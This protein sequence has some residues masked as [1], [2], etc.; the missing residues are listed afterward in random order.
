MESTNSYSLLCRQ[1]CCKAWQLYIPWVCR[2]VQLWNNQNTCR[3]ATR[4]R[5]KTLFLIWSWRLRILETTPPLSYN[6]GYQ[7]FVSRV[8]WDVWVSAA[9]RERREEVSGTKGTELIS[10]TAKLPP[11]GLLWVSSNFGVDSGQ[12]LRYLFSAFKTIIVNSFMS[13]GKRLVNG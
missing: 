9:G 1:C 10:I 5:G 6:R 4:R 13:V 3:K 7:R 11:W 12:V 2:L 8:R